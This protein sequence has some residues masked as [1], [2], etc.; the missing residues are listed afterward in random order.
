MIGSPDAVS[1]NVIVICWIPVSKLVDEPTS[2]VTLLPSIMTGGIVSVPKP[3]PNDVGS[4]YI[5]KTVKGK[6]IPSESLEEL[7]ETFKSEGIKLM[8]EEQA[9]LEPVVK[10]K[11]GIKTNGNG[12]SN[13][14][15]YASIKSP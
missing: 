1:N 5:E 6:N 2:N 14:Y 11:R 7:L 12:E 4:S 9:A 10:K 13:V 3:W 15:K 8:N